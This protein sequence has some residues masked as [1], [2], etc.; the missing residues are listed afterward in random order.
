MIRNFRETWYSP[1]FNEASRF[2]IRTHENCSHF[3]THFLKIVHSIHLFPTYS[4]QGLLRAS[5]SIPNLTYVHPNINME[6]R[7]CNRAAQAKTSNDHLLPKLFSYRNLLF[8]ESS[9]N[10]R[11]QNFRNVLFKIYTVCLSH[12]KKISCYEFKTLD[13]ALNDCAGGQ[14]LPPQPQLCLSYL[15]KARLR[16][17]RRLHTT[18]PVSGPDSG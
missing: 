2:L 3:E 6:L 7:I 14:D 12:S 13:K 8:E 1:R 4:A 18:K 5:L 9:L 10:L 15:T 11:T 16:F 17:P